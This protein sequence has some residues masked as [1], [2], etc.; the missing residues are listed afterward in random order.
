LKNIV[1]LYKI[2]SLSVEDSSSE[3]RRSACHQKLKKK[4]KQTMENQKENL[5]KKLEINKEKLN[6]VQKKKENLER[7]RKTLEAKIANQEFQLQ[8]LQ[9]TETQ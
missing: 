2:P 3:G 9:R 8:V 6:N 4:G 5:I 1:G 7:E